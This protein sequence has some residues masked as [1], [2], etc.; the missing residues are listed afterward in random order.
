MSAGVL[1]SCLKFPYPCLSRRHLALSSLTSF[2]A[3]INRTDYGAD[4]GFDQN[5]AFVGVGYNFDKHIK[6]E[7]GYLNQDIRRKGPDL[8]DHILSVNLFLAY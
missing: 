4:D 1:G 7:I 2:F 5:R 6:T 8:M 3:N